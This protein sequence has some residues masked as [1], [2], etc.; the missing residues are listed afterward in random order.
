MKDQTNAFGISLVYFEK[1]RMTYLNNSLKLIYTGVRENLLQIY[2][3]T[4]FCFI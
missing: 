4:E 2:S 3:T 1:G